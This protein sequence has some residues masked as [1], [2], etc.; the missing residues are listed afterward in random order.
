MTQRF[1]VLASDLSAE[2]SKS[3]FNWLK[4]NDCG[5]WHWIDN[6]WLVYNE[7]TW[8]ITA[9]KLRDALVKAAPAKNCL[10]LEIDE[11]ITWAGFGPTS[12]ER[13]MFRWIKD[14]G[15]GKD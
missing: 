5:W 4:E 1:V 13:N 8:G 12:K 10:V 9:Q 15:W 7:E 2:E 3:F 6:C 14:K 11:P